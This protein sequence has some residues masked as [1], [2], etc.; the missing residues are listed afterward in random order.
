M[1]K[2]LS[3]MVALWAGGVLSVGVAAFALRALLPR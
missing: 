2:K 3:W 1:V